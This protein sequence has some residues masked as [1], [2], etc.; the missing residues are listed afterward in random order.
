[1]QIQ[2]FYL[3]QSLRVKGQIHAAAAVNIISLICLRLCK[4]SVC[5]PRLQGNGS[6]TP[7]N[8]SQPVLL[9]QQQSW[10]LTQFLPVKRL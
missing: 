10:A 1:M 3:S 6:Q 7:G 4:R 5:L 9:P 8:V 2:L